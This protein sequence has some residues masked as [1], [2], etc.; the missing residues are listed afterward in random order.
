MR[1]QPKQP[2]PEKKPPKP[3]QKTK[4][5]SLSGS[6]IVAAGRLGSEAKAAALANKATSK[7]APR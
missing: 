5:Q 4:T 1:T 7:K 6:G 3:A 2:T